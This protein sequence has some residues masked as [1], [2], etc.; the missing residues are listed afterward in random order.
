MKIPRPLVT[1]EHGSW[2]VLLVPMVV[3]AGSVGAVSVNAAILVVA[4]LGAFMSYVPLQGILRALM[5][6]PRGWHALRP[7]L[8]WGWVYCSIALVSGAF[9]LLQ[10]YSRL[11]LIGAA[12]A[13]LFAG[14]FFLARRFGKTASS[15]FV[16]TAGLTL[17][18]PAM[19]YVLTGSLDQ[20]AFVLY[21][22]N[23][24]FFGCGV[25]YVHMKIRAARIRKSDWTLPDK[26]ATG[27][28]NLLYHTGVAV[29]ILFL[30]LDRITPGIALAAFLPMI[31]QAVYGTY[32]LSGQVS[33]PRLGLGLLAQSIIFSF[34][35]IAIVRA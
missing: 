22:L 8:F 19:Y 7:M 17:G 10:G 31:G 34:L 30:S 29:L 21:L 20:V 1:R 18:A 33:F 16:A 13:L 9:L 14:N 26:L 6:G 32:R 24:L 2:A 11:L 3:A 35:W 12:G 25:F 28:M 23:L 27:K 4:A 15:D 5:G